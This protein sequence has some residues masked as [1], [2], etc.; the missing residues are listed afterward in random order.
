MSVNV[1]RYATAAERRLW[2]RPLCPHA[3]LRNLGAQAARSAATRMYRLLDE[4]SRAAHANPPASLIRTPVDPA[5]D[6]I[7]STATHEW[8]QGET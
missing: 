7:E 4:G 8:P 5:G 3:Q 2:R 1:S 6:Q